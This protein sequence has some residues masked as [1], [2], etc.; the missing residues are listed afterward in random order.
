EQ[1]GYYC[2][3][4]LQ[5]IRLFRVFIPVGVLALLVSEILL[6]AACYV[7]AAFLILDVSFATYLTADDG[8]ARIALVIASILLGLHFS[9][10]YTRIHVTS[11][12]QL[13]QDLCQVIGIALLGQGL[14]S[15]AYPGLRLGRGIMLLGSLLCL[16]A[17]FVWRV[18]YSARILSAVGGDRI[19]FIGTNQVIREMAS[20]IAVHPELGLSIAGYLVNDSDRDTEVVGGRILGPISA[21]LEIARA[22]KPGRIV[23]GMTERRDRMPVQD[24]LTLRFSGF[25]IEDA[26]TTYEVVCGRICTKEL[27]P[28]QLIFSGELGPRPASLFFQSVLNMSVAILGAILTLPLMI[29]VAIAVRVTSRGPVL[30]RQ[31]RVGI[32]GAPFTLFK[33]RSMRVDAEDA[34]GAVWAS[35]DDPRTTSIGRFLR[36]VRLD[37]LP[38]FFNVLRGEMSLVGPRPERPEFV[39]TLSEQIPYYRQRLCVKPG[40]TGWAQINYKYSDTLQD[41]ITKLEYDLYYVKHVSPS[42]DAYIIFHTLKTIVLSRGAQ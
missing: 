10:L 8:L 29:L 23:V 33:F 5:M 17:L 37:E 3:H 18:F 21:L 19:L 31:V 4:Y 26:G 14:I 2:K 9:D 22:E 41:T 25:K 1:Y 38:Q 12:L 24:L 20:H 40:I 27:R 28:G 7:L 32:D 30:Y 36:K 13:L 42:L 11:R 39:Q 15:Y 35:K 34:T 6:T 16:A